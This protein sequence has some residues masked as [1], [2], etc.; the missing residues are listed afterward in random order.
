MTKSEL[1]EE[2]TSIET[3]SP[4]VNNKKTYLDA[5]EDLLK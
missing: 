4:I 3:I 5:N 1:I 2:N